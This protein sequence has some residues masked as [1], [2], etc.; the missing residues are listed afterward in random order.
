MF[1]GTRLRRLRQT[2]V[3]RD[4]LQETRLHLRE[5]I[6]PFFVIE[7]RDR[8]EEVPSM[9]GVYRFTVD[10]LLK[11]L[12][13][14]VYR[15]IGGI[16]L[17]GIPME[18]D[19]SGAT[20]WNEQG[21]LQ[22]GCRSIKA[23]FP[24]LLVFTDLCLCSYTHHGHCG[25]LNSRG[26][27]DNDRTLDVLEK[28]AVSHAA[29]GSDVIAP[30]DMMDGRIG[31]IRRILDEKGFTHQLI[32][33]YSAKFA[34]AFYGPFREAA[35]SAPQLGDRKSYQLPPANRREALREMAEDLAEG[36]DMLM[37]KP[38]LAYLDIIR[39]ARQ[40]FT[41][42]LVAYNVSGEYAMVKA[43]A[44]SGWVDEE[45]MVKEILLGIKRA[46]AD[47]IITYHVKDLYGW[48]RGF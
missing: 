27:I 9:P 19:D 10:R 30:S 18:K 11:E 22:Q 46:G 4:L 41:A 3:V 16:L 14:P 32:L 48:E 15:E 38:A 37:V 34:S 1:P 47:L 33:A 44:Q 25:L 39:E 6:A 17:F 23:A 5:L 7:G 8:M 31:A 20:A 21:V 26:D 29:A 28:I 40:Q 35:H 2:P 36:A 12:E 24:E 42:P 45:R 13:G 43:A